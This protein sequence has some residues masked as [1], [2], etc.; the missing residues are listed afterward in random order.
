[1][2]KNRIPKQSL[3]TL[4]IVKK[5]FGNSLV[6]VYLYGSAVA[7]GL[8]QDS[9]IDVFVIINTNLP[10][11]TQREL[12]S[13]LMNISGTIGNQEGK[14]PLEVTVVK[15]EDI[16]PWHYPPKRQYIY[17]EWLRNE[18][19]EG[20][21]QTPVYDPD[22]SILITQVRKNS[23]SLMG[24]EASTLFEPVPVNDIRK[25]VKDSLPDLLDEIKGDERNVILTLARMWK[26]VVTGKITSKDKAAEWVI[27]RL[28]DKY[29]PL[30][31]IAKK[32]Y[33]GN[34]E[35]DWTEKDSEVNKFVHYMKNKIF[36]HLE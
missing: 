5:L 14:R 11:E 3:Q 33:L 31:N 21:L 27:L 34:Y 16:V 22:L 32:A 23:L 35:D 28:P 19:L 24:P 4:E 1:M 25:A 12:T 9:D 6:G 8:K 2:N 7:G 29:V 26:T 15:K 17:G 30:L 18:F 36:D 20:E 13:Q 10:K